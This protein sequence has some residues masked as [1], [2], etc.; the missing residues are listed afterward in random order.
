[1]L[2]SDRKLVDM[3]KNIFED[4]QNLGQVSSSEEYQH[5]IEEHLEGEDLL[6]E[7]NPKRNYQIFY[8][9]LLLTLAVLV[10]KL[11]DLQITKGSYNRF[12]AEG[13]RIRAKEIPSP[14]GV[15]LDRNGK[16]LASN[17]PSFDLEL[18][19]ADLPKNFSKR[20]ELFRQ[21]AQIAQ[22]EEETFQKITTAQLLSLEPIVLKE[23]LDRDEALLLEMKLQGIP[24]VEVAKR[25]K[26][27]YLSSA[28]LSHV[29]GYVGKIT[30]EEREKFPDYKLNDILGKSGVELVY[31]KDLQ[32]K[33]GKDQV[34]VNAQGQIQRILA[35][36]EPEP[37]KILT[38]SIDSSL[39]EKVSLALEAGVRNAGS[40]KG[41]AIL[42]KPTTGEILAMVS[43]PYFDN[44][45][46]VSEEVSKEYQK[47][48]E[49]K[50]RPL[51]NRAVSGQYPS[52]STIKP[53]VAAAALQEG[54]VTE[55]TTINAPGEIR[56]G[57]FVFPDWK[58]HGLT[59][60]RK[61]IAQSVNVF[62]YALG[63]GWDKIRGLGV[64]KMAIYFDKFGWGKKTG[65]DLPGEASGLIPTPQ[66][67][68]KAKG[69]HWYIG[70]TYHLAIGQ[71]D[72]LVT[73]LQLLN[74]VSS[75]ANGGTLYKPHLATSISNPDKS[76]QTEI[77]SEVLNSNFISTSHLQV[78]REGM[79]QAV[80]SGS[81]R[82]LSDLPVE[83]AGKTG[84]AQFGNEGKTHAWF[85]GFA[86]FDSPQISVIILVEGGGEG[87][88]AAV[89]IAKEILNFYFS[90]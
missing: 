85:V 4:F 49:D 80:T 6:E 13:N 61:A 5:P 8:L 76:N 53:L 41:V 36:V 56:I 83:V 67:K 54:V 77:K 14:R 30:K 64:E 79:R 35:T 82:A 3:N 40:K 55:K 78:V 52:G 73:P 10:F 62:F 1:M 17:L 22:V 71:G 65:V 51:I 19:P 88:A 47:L 33:D 90:R 89:P 29:L 87:H 86:P 16:E 38:L 2:I 46:L 28:S 84:T 23:N 59:D 63:G 50:N 42:Q 58:T 48:V 70:D 69:E 37:G 75:I 32:G 31:E 45:N 24:A 25:P 44:D 39:Q 21:I 15:I 7:D 60:I 43:F 66:W 74:A 11:L 34:E 18:I 20:K 72:I 68:E 57:Q 81:A 9:V 26:R 27:T 12:L